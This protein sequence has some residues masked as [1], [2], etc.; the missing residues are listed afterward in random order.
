MPDSCPFCGVRDHEAILYRRGRRGR[1]YQRAV[2]ELRTKGAHICWICH[3][4]IDMA[5]PVNDK[6]SWTLDHYYPL[7][8]YP[9]LGLVRTNHREAHRTCNSSKGNTLPHSTYIVRD[10]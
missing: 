9:C 1:P 3:S 7:D 5:L 6:W 4:A 8:T 10:W 2:A